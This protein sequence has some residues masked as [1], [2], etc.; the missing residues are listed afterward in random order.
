MG[1]VLGATACCGL[2][3]PLLGVV[4]DVV[5]ARGGVAVGVVSVAPGGLVTGRR[6]G[7]CDICGGGVC[8]IVGVVF[9]SPHRKQEMRTESVSL[10]DLGLGCAGGG[11]LQK[12]GDRNRERQ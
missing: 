10:R 1:G 9:F 3:C 11:S 6:G 7:V 4:V 12:S 2:S 8:T 5:A